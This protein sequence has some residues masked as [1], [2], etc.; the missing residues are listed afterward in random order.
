MA[1]NASS[2]SR[3]IIPIRVKVTAAIVSVVAVVEAV[4]LVITLTVYRNEMARAYARQTQETMMQLAQNLDGVMSETEE[5]LFYNMNIASRNIF[6]YDDRGQSLEF[7]F[8]S[9][10]MSYLLNFLNNAEMGVNS[11]YT[12]NTSGH[13]YFYHRRTSKWSDLTA[14]AGSD[15]VKY[16][17]ENLDRLER[18]KGK[19]ELKAFPDDRNHIYLIKSVLRVTPF[20][21]DGIMCLELDN[22]FLSRYYRR[23]EENLGC[24][25][26]IL[27]ADGEILSSGNSG[28]RLAEAYS[29]LSPEA[30]ARISAAAEDGSIVRAGDSILDGYLINTAKVTGKGWTVVSFAERGQVMRAYYTIRNMLLIMA[31]LV[32]TVA[33]L[34]SRLLSGSITRGIMALQDSIQT[35]RQG[36]GIKHA[37]IRSNDEIAYLGESFNAMVDELDKNVERIAAASVEKDTAEYN[38]LLAQLNPHFLYNTLESIRSLA[39]L[40]GEEEIVGSIR[41]LSSLLRVS[42]RGN[43][44][45]IPLRNEIEYIN[46]YLSLER[47]VRGDRLV[48][49][50]LL[51][52]DIGDDLVPKLIL[53]PIVENSIL[54]GISDQTGEAVIIIT[55]RETE[56]K[57]CIQ[58]SDNGS[59]MTKEQIEELFNKG[60]EQDGR[61][62][63]VNSVHRRIQLLYGEE[64]GM[65][66]EST[67]G[68]GTVV[69]LMLPVIRR[70]RKDEAE[71]IPGDGTGDRSFAETAESGENISPDVRM[72][73]ADKE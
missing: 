32:M 58:V 73:T 29:R 44:R 48:S 17:D 14:F 55:A 10:H 40:H 54:H 63:G 66:I 31:F 2:S 13:S 42:F 43:E 62:I 7:I 51:T 52:G 37:D 39:R 5:T 53:Q 27:D 4:I 64:Y 45:E 50:V 70:P 59:G 56:G 69:E 23:I 72:M 11:I 36:E 21:Y 46:Q 61:H 71:E 9:Q 49:D 1:K 60:A 19:T 41:S 12:R 24:E 28:W 67:P 18:G 6:G 3:R 30:R 65:H 20:R 68:E 57:L 34:L 25:V 35:F 26:V 22:E 15:A 38:A 16:I 8:V 47:L 33:G